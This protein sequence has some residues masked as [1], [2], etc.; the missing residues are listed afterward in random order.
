M[1]APLSTITNL[2][3]TLADGH[4][5]TATE[6][7]NAVNTIYTYINNTLLA[8]G[9]NVWTTKGDILV[10]DGSN[11][12]RLA[13]G[14]NGQ[15]LTAQSGQPS[16]LQWVS[17]ATTAALTTK[18]DLLVYSSTGPGLLRKAVG[19]DG[20]VLTARASN[21]D[22]V[23]WETP[24]SFP[25]GMIAMWSGS[26]AS[27]PSGWVL[28]DGNNSTPNL[29][30]LMIVGAGNTSPA[31]T[32]GMGLMNPGGPHGDNSAGAGLGPSHT[33]A[34]GFINTFAA[35]GANGVSNVLPLQDTTITPK[36]YA[37]AFI[38]KT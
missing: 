27:I 32:G 15:A 30:G 12:V 36:Y 16:G 21:A 2:V 6:W 1:A 24:T 10:H 28:C 17:L 25:S 34:Y 9:L 35:G 4:V 14:S 26:L 8:S 38:M 31:A 20:Q 29:Q 11:I 33:H 13:V 23:A 5:V 19:S 7:N 37:L 18:G 22:G 3:G